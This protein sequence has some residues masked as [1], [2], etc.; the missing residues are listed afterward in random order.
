VYNAYKAVSETAE[1]MVVDDMT[2]QECLDAVEMLKQLKKHLYVIPI[3]QHCNL[4]R[5]LPP[6]I[7]SVW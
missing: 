3:S 2:E 4:Q 6:I 7:G 5:L 1:A